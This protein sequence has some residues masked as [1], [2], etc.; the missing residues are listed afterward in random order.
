VIVGATLVDGTGRT[1][2]RDAVVVL[3][4]GKIEAAGPRQSV[5]IPDGV[6]TLDAKGTW[7]LPGL[8]DAHVHLSQTGWA[9]GRP[10][11][12]DLRDLYPYEAAIAR[13]RS[14]PETFFRSWLACGVTAVFDVGGFPWTVGLQARSRTDTEAPHVVASGPILSTLDHWI[15]L[16][17]ERQFVYLPNDSAARA[18]VHYVKS[19]GA[20]A[21]KFYFIVTAGRPFDT[22]TSAAIAAGEEARKVGLPL[23]VHATEL[24][25]AKAALRAQPH[26]LVHSVWDAPVDREFLDLARAAGTIYCPTL[27][28]I[29]GYWRMSDALRSGV[30]PT[31]DDPYGAVDSLTRAHVAS[32]PKFAARAAGRRITPDSLRR[33]RRQTMARNLMLVHRAGIPIAL[34][35]DAGNPLTLHGPSIYAE[36]ETMQK[37]G[38]APMAVIVAAT[39]DGARALGRSDEFGTIAPGK[40]GDLIVVDADPT[41]DVAHLRQLRWVVRGGVVRPPTEFRTVPR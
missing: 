1:P 20:S 13:L 24:R 34:G 36:L 5:R 14:Q 35:T 27:A 40:A 30:A 9:D 28:V 29:E 3:R 6:D 10:D 32:T 12:L 23:I 41:R 19:L 2:V 8:V 15:N 4:D 26:L 38:M 22:V 21:A 33:A 18:G 39:R 16:P 31:I 25:E 37:A 17:A 11:A 7:I